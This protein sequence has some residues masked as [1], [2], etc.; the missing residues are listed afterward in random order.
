MLL[1]DGRQCK[2][3]QRFKFLIMFYWVLEFIFALVYVLYQDLFHVFHVCFSLFFSFSVL[4]SS[5][6]SVFCL[7]LATCFVLALQHDAYNKNHALHTTIPLLNP[8]H[9]ITVLA[10]QHDAVS[11]KT[12]HSTPR[13]LC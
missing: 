13:S 8:C 12:T 4:F 2:E 9:F 7:L 1:K 6:F 10:L 3:K 11:T 5:V